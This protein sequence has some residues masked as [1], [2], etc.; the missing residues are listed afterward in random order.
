MTVRRSPKIRIRK[1]EPQMRK[2]ISFIF[3]AAV[4]G[5]SVVVWSNVTASGSREAPQASQARAF[6]SDEMKRGATFSEQKFHDMSL[7]YSQE[8]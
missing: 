5:A 1:G 2:I 8:H 7:V 6:T 4:V 3:V